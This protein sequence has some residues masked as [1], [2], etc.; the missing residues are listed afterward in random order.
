MDASDTRPMF[1]A[2]V[3]RDVGAI[4][5]ILMAGGMQQREI[6]RLVGMGQSEVSEI[7][8][9]R[10]VMAYDVLV[11]VAD[12]LGIPR[13]MM[14]LA[15]DEQVQE[16]D[17]DVERRKLLATAG[18]IMFGVPVFGEPEPLIVRRVRV[19]PPQ[20]IGM[21]DVQVYGQTVAQLRALQA[22]VGGRAVRE[23]LAATAFA[24]DELLK[25]EAAVEVHRRLRLLVSNAHRLAGLAAG[26]VGLIDDYRAHIH[27][28]LDLAV[29]SPERIAQ[30]LCSAGSMEKELGEP[31][32][33]LKLLQLG[34]ISA[35]DCS[36]SRVGAVIRGES[37]AGY[38]AFGNRAMAKQELATARQVF[39]D[40]D[41]TQPL[42]EFASYGRGDSMWAVCEMQ[43]GKF[44]VA[45]SDILNALDSRP[46]DDVWFR[47]LDTIILAT[48]SMQAGELRE[49]IQ[50]TQRALGLIRQVGS[51]RLE[52]RMLLLADLL[53]SR[54]DS[55]CHDLAR[56]IRTM[57][58]IE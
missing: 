36:D 13:G 5:R 24:G 43:L 51:R 2:C 57:N 34:Q 16:V 10:R 23:P 53:A 33:A 46:V 20:R 9:G 42:P 32:Y 39:A 49:G 44:E 30:V 18:M 14:G 31:D 47:V 26:D 25:A 7:L 28:A 15:G 27:Q 41:R 50:Q 55:T 12:G 54:N 3:S 56:V 19:N 11:R 48:I 37:I 52:R 8:A 45:R 4:F 17:E 22:Q 38:I 58:G 40:A 21:V 1:E 6:A 35:G 29:G